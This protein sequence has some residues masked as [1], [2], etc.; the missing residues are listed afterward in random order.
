VGLATFDFSLVMLYCCCCC[1][2]SIGML[3]GAVLGL[4]VIACLRHYQRRY[5]I[6][7]WSVSRLWV[8]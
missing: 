3:L 1:S 8:Q 2:V 6:V 5:S 7:S 4:V